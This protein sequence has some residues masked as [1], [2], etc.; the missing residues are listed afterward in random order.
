MQD[1]CCMTK[2]PI[3]ALV[4]TKHYYTYHDEKKEAIREN[5]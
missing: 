5:K 1:V 4:E 3:D 2:V